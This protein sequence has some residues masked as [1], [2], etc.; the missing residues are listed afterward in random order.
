MPKPIEI[1]VVSGKGGTGKTVLTA[2]LAALIEDKVVADCDVDAPDLHLLLRPSIRREEAFSGNQRATIDAEMCTS[3]G[4]CLEVCRFKAIVAA[5]ESGDETYHVDS[6]DCEG[7][8]VCT[9]S[10]P[11]GAITMEDTQGGKWFVSDTRFGTLVHASL[12]VAEENSG[13]LVTIVRSEARK[14]AIETGHRLVFIDGPPGVGCP[15]IASIAGVDLAV[16]VTE[17]TLSGLH[18]LERVLGLTRHFGVRTGVVVNKYDL[19]GE[20]CLQILEFLRINRVPLLGRIPFDT[21]VNRAVAAG[22]T[23]VEYSDSKVA[24][25]IRFASEQ[26]MDLIRKE[27]GARAAEAPKE[28]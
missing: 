23:V 25:E 15:V 22:K 28:C 8:G 6:L 21:M 12:G 9:W 17:P 24:R 26:M 11:V 14:V 19:N 10:C 13:K 3:C 18:D 5:G 4:K 7:C 2:C 27:Q 20:V 1:A 16:V